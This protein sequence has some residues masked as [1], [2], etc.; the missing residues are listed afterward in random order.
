MS[1][2]EI[3]LDTATL[4]A[5]ATPL[6][7]RLGGGDSDD[8]VPPVIDSAS[9]RE[10]WRASLAP[11]DDGAW[12]AR[13]TH[14]D[15]SPTA[16]IADPVPDSDAGWVDTLRALVDSLLDEELSPSDDR[17]DEAPFT[18]VVEPIVSFAAEPCEFGPV[19]APSAVSDLRA[20]LAGRLRRVL[21]QALF[22]EFKLAADPEAEGVVSVTDVP[23]GTGRP[24]YSAFV[25]RLTADGL[26]GFF[27]RYPVAGRLTATIVSEWRDRVVRLAERARADRATLAD[28][29]DEGT[30]PG[31]VVDVSATGDPH[32][33]GECV[34]RVEFDSGLTLAYKPR[35]VDAHAAFDE[36]CEW[37]ATETDLS[38]PHRATVVTRDG[39]GWVEWLEQRDCEDEAAVERYYRRIG[40]L[41]CLSYVLRFTDGNYQNLVAVGERPALID[42]ET[43]CRPAY[44]D[45]GGFGQ[46]ELAEIVDESVLSTGLFPVVTAEDDIVG[47][48]GLDDPGERETSIPTRNFQAV[49]TDEMELT[50]DH[51]TT[52]DGRNQPTVDGQPH[53]PDDYGTE[54]LAGFEQAASVVAAERDRLAD[55]SGPLSGF[56][57]VEIRTFLRSTMEYTRVRRPLVTTEYLRSGGKRDVRVETLLK[58]VDF[59]AADERRTALFRAERAA[60]DRGDVPRLTIQTDDTA[61]SCGG[62]TVPGV[63]EETP[64]EQLLAHVAE[65]GESTLRE[66]ADYLKL[67]YEPRELRLPDPPSAPATAP[68]LTDDRLR[69]VVAGVVDRVHD[70]AVET[71]DGTTRWYV[72]EG[73]PGGVHVHDLRDDLYGGRLGLATFGAAAQRVLSGPVARRAATITDEAVAPVLDSVRADDLPTEKL[74]VCHGRGSFVYALVNLWRLRDDDRFLDAAVRVADTVPEL[75]G[76]DDVYYLI[77]GAAGGALALSTLADATGDSRH[78]QT[79]VD[80][81]DHLLSERI[82]HDGVRVW[83][84]HDGPERALVG[85]GHGIAG[86]ALALGRVGATV[87][88]PRFKQAA[89]DA[90]QFERDLYDSERGGWPDFRLGTYRR[91]W[92]AGAAGIALTRAELIAVDDRPAYRRDLDRAVESMQTGKLHD[93]D[94]LCCGNLGHAAVTRRVDELCN[95]PLLA[96][97]GRALAARSL[98]RGDDDSTLAYD[99]D[100]WYNPTLFL[101]DPGVGYAACR[102]L[103]STVPSLLAVE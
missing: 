26:A 3:P 27:E 48:G 28:R 42:L 16:S 71:D 12:A 53:G 84:T 65:L 6:Y 68:R 32:D 80:L 99:T 5:R 1:R 15:A 14:L 64:F 103:D 83:E 31:P 98:A 8:S 30:A 82:D 39:Y 11:A 89:A 43:V 20:E 92:C 24:R 9:L 60:I 37:L 38:L 56:E 40:T 33:G 25:A 2:D 91:G 54:I 23:T 50:F 17:E 70:A 44:P 85:A 74:G 102:L 63:L 81:C 75:V 67:A 66:Q 19:L 86:I 4:T 58:R 79:A 47:V 100:Q 95:R 35:P 101:G 36:F 22:V 78:R 34:S 87:D 97:R 46:P 49:N 94:H 52:H 77:G 76:D 13:L 72:R 41:A 69:S 21:A 7:D 88:A 73:R 93:R 61:V 62:R 10:E 18:H 96:R 55:P 90:L 51:T 57:S 29:F 59:T 45:E